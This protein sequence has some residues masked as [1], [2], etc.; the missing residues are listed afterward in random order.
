MVILEEVNE[1]VL[2]ATERDCLVFLSASCHGFFIFDCWVC[3]LDEEGIGF[4]DLPLQVW[5]HALI[6]GL[7]LRRESLEDSFGEIGVQVLG[8][9]A[10]DDELILE[11]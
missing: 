8:V 3:L 5:L 10:I 7:P 6:L 4:M 2:G 9:E 11:V 1:E